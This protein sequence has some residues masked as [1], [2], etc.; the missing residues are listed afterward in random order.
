MRVLLVLVPFLGVCFGVTLKENKYEGIYVAIQDSVTEDQNLIGRIKEIFTDAS[1]LLFRAT[2]ERVYFGEINI[3]VPKSWSP[4]GD[5]Q[6]VQQSERGYFKIEDGQLITP[7]TFGNDICGLG[8]TY[9]YL[10]LSFVKNTSRT[11]FGK[12][13]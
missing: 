13:G 8:G 7:R 1:R 5:A 4:Q 11:D 6:P 2:G 3:V 10:P 9:T 12:H